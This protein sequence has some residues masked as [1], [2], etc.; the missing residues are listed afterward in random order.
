VVVGTS[1]TLPG[2]DRVGWKLQ[3]EIVLLLAWAP[4]ILL[5]IAHPLVAR[6]IADHSAFLTERR[7]RMRRFHHTLGAMLQ[8]CFGTEAEARAVLARIHAIHGRVNGQLSHAAGVFPAGTSYSARD[9]ALL[10]WV[11]A[12]LLDMNLRVYE[13]Y[14]GPLSVEEKD[15][16]CA[17]ASAIEDALGIPRGRLPRSFVELE[18]Y[19]EA[20]LGSGEII[21]TD[22][23]RALARAIVWPPAPRLA[24]PAI[25]LMRLPTVGL[26]PPTIREAYG[27][28]WDSRSDAMLRV[29]AGITRKM[30]PVI[31]SVVR[32]WPAAR[33]PACAASRSRCGHGGA[34]PMLESNRH[35][36]SPPRG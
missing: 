14:V 15:R 17:E 21:V 30:L 31:P 13:L 28:S 5:Q 3:R 27:F 26:L 32:Y 36:D 24:A 9:P 19:M 23:A 7:G 35:A 33:R 2:V 20:M 34:P 10:A 29:S 22:A 12:T 18:A 16:Y 25:H 11:H 4:A 6:G 1:E 8:L